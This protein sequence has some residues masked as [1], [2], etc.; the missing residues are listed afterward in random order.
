MYQLIIT[1][2]LDGNKVQTIP[3]GG[4]P[5]I[6]DGETVILLTTNG[7]TSTILQGMDM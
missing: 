5:T 3:V 4:L 2:T 7:E 6:T 1:I